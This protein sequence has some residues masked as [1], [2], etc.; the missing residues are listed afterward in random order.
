MSLSYKPSVQFFSSVVSCE[1]S[2]LETVIE[3]KKTKLKGYEVIL[4]NTIIFPEGGGQVK[5]DNCDVINFNFDGYFQPCDYGYLNDKRV[6]QVTRKF[7][8]A[9]HFVTEPLSI[10]E[11]VKQVI[12]WDR[13]FDHMQQHSGQ[14]LITAVIDREFKYPTIS[15]WL[16][17]SVSY[18]KLGMCHKKIKLER[19]LE[20][21]CRCSI[22]NS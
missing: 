11:N 4:E 19:L 12:D 5:V 6:Y 18:I 9:L 15:W 10:G 1:P 17:E 20:F 3:G 8:K 14:H 22:D 13:R 7:D 21:L 2:E 16:G